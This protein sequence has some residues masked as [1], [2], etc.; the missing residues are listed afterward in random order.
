[1]KRGDEKE[2]YEQFL[3]VGLQHP[4]DTRGGSVVYWLRRWTCDAMVASSIPS[5]GGK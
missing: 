2:T 5:R 1:V 3:S 4:H